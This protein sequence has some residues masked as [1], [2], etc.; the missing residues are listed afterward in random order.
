MIAIRTDVTSVEWQRLTA[1]ADQASELF[2]S[3]DLFHRDILDDDAHAVITA[4]E[5][6]L[7][8]VSADS[9]V[10]AP[11]QSTPALRSCGRRVGRHPIPRTD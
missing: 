10:A 6:E 9:I 8:N 1:A 2:E 7:A 4:L 3:I 5:R 11:S